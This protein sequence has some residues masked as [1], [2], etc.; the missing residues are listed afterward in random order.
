MEKTIDELIATDE[1]DEDDLYMHFDR[2]ASVEPSMD[3]CD[4][5]LEARR[6]LGLVGLEVQEQSAVDLVL[7]AAAAGADKA[8]VCRLAR[9]LGESPEDVDYALTFDPNDER[10]GLDG[11]SSLI[12]DAKAFHARLRGEDLT[13]NE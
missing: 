4:V 5:A 9:I 2:V 7:H 8:A 1:F 12:A 13:T 6:I 11:L 3:W 10:R